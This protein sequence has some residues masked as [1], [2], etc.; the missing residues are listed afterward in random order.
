MMTSWQGDAF[1]IAGTLFGGITV[2]SGF[3]SQMASKLWYFRSCSSYAQEVVE[4]TVKSPLYSS[5]VFGTNTAY[6]LTYMYDA[7]PSRTL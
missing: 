7:L 3:S 4:Q 5:Y 6:D 2:T 1:C